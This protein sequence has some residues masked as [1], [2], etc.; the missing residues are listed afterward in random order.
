M[1]QQTVV[2]TELVCQPMTSGLGKR[3]P[4]RRCVVYLAHVHPSKLKSLETCL[5]IAM[6]RAHLVP[7]LVHVA[8]S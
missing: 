5:G 3:M 1:M 2:V 7:M 6:R 8:H 4:S